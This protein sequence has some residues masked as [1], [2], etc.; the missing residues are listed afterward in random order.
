VPTIS[1]NNE[2]IAIN[3]V[4]PYADI[5][6]SNYGQAADAENNDNPFMKASFTDDNSEK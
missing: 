2:E 5:L 3:K 6:K 1:E 4:L